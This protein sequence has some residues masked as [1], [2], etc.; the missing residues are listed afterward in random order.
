MLA[1]TGCRVGEVSRL[2]VEGGDGGVPLRILIESAPGAD[3][4]L[5][6]YSAR[7]RKDLLEAA[8]G[9]AVEIQA[10]PPGLLRTVAAD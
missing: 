5:E 7:N 2:R 1:Y 10:V 9:V 4:D 8:L 3:A 6:L